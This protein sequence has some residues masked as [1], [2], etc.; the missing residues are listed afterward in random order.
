MSAFDA[1]DDLESLESDQTLQTFVRGD[2]RPSRFYF[3]QV[4]L[5]QLFGLSCVT[6]L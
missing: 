1:L 2:Y 5:V 4:D 3:R 6:V